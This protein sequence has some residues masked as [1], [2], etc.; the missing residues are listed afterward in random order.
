METKEDL[1]LL[2]Q[3]APDTPMGKLLRTFWQPV[4]ISAGLEKGTAR[5][6]RVLSEDLTLYRSQIGNTYLVGGRCAHRCVEL[7]LGWV[8][9]E[10][11]RCMYHGWRYDG[12]G[13]C[14]EMPAEKRG[15][16]DLVK[17]AGYPT[18]E[19]CGLVFAYMGPGPA[20]AFDLPRK[21]VLEEPGRLLFTREQT[22]DTNWFQQVENSLDS[23]HLS[24][25]HV[26]GRMSR[27]GEEVTTAL[28]ELEFFETDAGIRQIATRGP[29]N[30]RIS[31]WTFPNNNHIRSP[32]PSKGDPWNDTS[33]WAVPI[34]DTKTMRFSVITVPSMGEEVDK[35]QFEDRVREFNPAGHY[36]DLWRKRL[37][38]ESPSNLLTIQDY[39][40]VRGQGVIVDRTQ[41][42]LAQSDAGIAMLRRIC[43]REMAAI[44]EGRPTKQWK[45]LQ[46]APDMP[47][48]IPD[49]V[50]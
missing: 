27:F 39:V 15:R 44:M 13:Q 18:H 46:K 9:G 25:A 8:E 21:E 22:W 4:A 26:W 32:G 10:E 12:R 43:F 30:V 19:Y 49:E 6:L 23:V 36:E 31:N 14:T 38:E 42:R 28:P 20:P 40:A 5:P 24:F 3:T 29:K 41:E 35:R 50:R 2:S 37:P 1:R 16:P 34:D 45:K 48:Q 7:H 47:I 17:I 11:I 33:V